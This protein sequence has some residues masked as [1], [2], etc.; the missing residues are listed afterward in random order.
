MS[1]RMNVTAALVALLA[2]AFATPA[3][4]AAAPAAPPSTP[5]SAPPPL[6]RTDVEAWLDGMIPYAMSRADIAGVVVVVVKDDQ[7]LLK[8]GY[9][10]SHV[11]RR[12]PVD[13]DLTLF[14]VGSVSKLFTWTAVMQQVEQGKLDL[15]K[16][17][18][19]YLDFRV[20]PLDGKP[21][22]LRNLMTHTAGFEE[23]VKNMSAKD[24]TR[25]M[26]FDEFERTQTPARVFPPG[27]TP[28]YSN[29]GAGLA[30]YVVERV[31]GEP[32]NAYV[33]R[34]IFRPL[35]MFHAS[36][37]QP[38]PI[39]LARDMSSAYRK[40]TGEEKP[41]ELVNPP[42]AG[43]LAVSGGDIARFMIAHLDDGRLGEAQ[44]LRPETARLMHAPSF[45][46]TPPLNGMTLGFFQEDRNGHRVIGHAGDLSYH[47]SDLHL[48]LDDRVGLFISMNSAGAGSDNETLRRLIYRGFMDRYFPAPASAPSPTWKDA[49]AD[50]RRIAG[51]YTL[52]RRGVTS[53]LSVQTLIQQARVVMDDKGLIS[54]PLLDQLLGS[55]P[56]KWREVGAM[57]WQEEGGPGLLKAALDHGRVTMLFTDDIPQFTVLQPVSAGLNQAWTAPVFLAGLAVLVV[58]VL[59][60]PFAALVRRRYR[61]PFA[62]SGRRALFYRLSRAGAL[63]GLVFFAAWMALLLSLSQDL[64]PSSASSDILIRICQAIGLVAVFGAA[65][66]WANVAVVW[67][68]RSA[69]WWA[70]ISAPLVALGCV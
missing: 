41:F 45:Q 8:K 24:A 54:I 65:L 70:R 48:L 16:D 43:A 11:A 18:N 31:S 2:L 17:V 32:F 13:P 15:D 29:Y 49:K 39:H 63:A 28:A 46:L 50:G 6:T 33:E 26:S 7:I 1:G 38:L 61:A 5:S 69:S 59:A 55:P 42:P 51:F 12:T 56:R 58:A 52:S 62:L 66:A 68:D 36:F 30:A 27:K 35:G 67:A 4:P 19:T 60:W 57:T 34:H 23:H 20:P 21:V 44:I 40:G 64:A 25:L 3:S 10:Y 53:L 47:H 22:T 14:R 9:G 37:D